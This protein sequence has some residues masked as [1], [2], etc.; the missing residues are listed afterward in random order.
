MHGWLAR[1][2]TISIFL[3]AP[4]VASAV[5]TSTLEQRFEEVFR[6]VQNQ[7][8][9]LESQRKLLTTQGESI[10]RLQAAID[11]PWGADACRTHRSHDRY[12]SAGASENNELARY[13]TVPPLG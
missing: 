8:E 3:A 4:A 5:E 12:R 13:Q 9:E 2:I 7:Q 10:E 11:T 1:T 6:L